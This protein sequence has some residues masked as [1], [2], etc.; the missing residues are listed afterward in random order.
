MESSLWVRRG[1]PPAMPKPHRHD[2]VEVNLVLEGR[3]D[4]LFGG[5]YLSVTAGQM[6]IFW[7]AT[8]HRL[9]GAGEDADGDVCWVHV[10]LST[11]LGWGLPDRDLGQVLTM[12]P[13]IVP[14]TAIGRDV[15][16]MFTAW[17][18]ELTHDDTATIV[19]LEAQALVRRA[20]RHARDASDTDSGRAALGT[21]EAMRNVTAMA[22]FTVAHF[23]EPISTVDIAEAAHLNPNY[24][25][26][27]FRRAVGT[28][29]GSYLTRCRVAEAQRLLITTAMT[30]AEIA[31][32][33]GFGSQSS[34][35]EHFARACGRSPGAYRRE[36]R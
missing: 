27:L 4:Y 14:A 20:L 15:A 31:Y 10:P 26:T 18:E 30:T 21:G 1:A 24:A 28:T 5:S 9:V 11:V 2:D 25:M 23:R 36:L 35:Y 19:L 8:P 33:A 17:C 16:A 34:F 12:R 7:A 29:L 3:L 6:A 13:V 22:Q 32:A